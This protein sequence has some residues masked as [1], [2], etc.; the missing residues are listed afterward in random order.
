MSSV[1]SAASFDD[2]DIEKWSDSLSQTVAIEQSEKQALEQ[3]LSG[4]KSVPGQANEASDNPQLTKSP[5]EVEAEKEAS[6]MLLRALFSGLEQMTGVIAGVS[7]EFQP[8]CKEAVIE[9]AYP[10]FA[11]QDKNKLFGG[12]VDE[13]TLIITLMTLVVVSVT[14][15]KRLK[16]EGGKHE[17]TAVTALS[18]SH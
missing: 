17:S 12:Y 2:L 8:S 4:E 15:V 5:E 1:E 3:P 6:A 13:A 16:A 11:K 9:A 14:Q 7:F 10:V 18:E